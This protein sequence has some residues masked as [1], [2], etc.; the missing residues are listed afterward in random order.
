[1]SR[2]PNEPD[3]KPQDP[4]TRDPLMVRKSPAGRADGHSAGE[5][6]A[7]ASRFL[8]RI[9]AHL[10][11][12]PDDRARCRFLDRQISGW[13]ARYARFLATGG[14]S[15]PAA[16]CADP[17]HAADFLLTIAALAARR[18]ALAGS[19]GERPTRRGCLLA[20][21][22]DAEAGMKAAAKLL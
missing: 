15:E 3:A 22:A 8:C 19:A 4:R 12:L 5:T 20:A 17:P 6:G 18:G 2:E 7:R 9:D 10:P 11:S 1:M 14:A 16:N 21:I 13:Q